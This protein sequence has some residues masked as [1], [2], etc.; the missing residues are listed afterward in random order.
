M[1]MKFLYIL[2]PFKNELLYIIE[3]QKKVKKMKINTLFYSALV[4]ITFTCFSC[5]SSN[6]QKESN[7]SETQ[8]IVTEDMSDIQNK[9]TEDSWSFEE[10]IYET[11]THE[12]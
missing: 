2:A 1:K 5:S 7:N 10:K 12:D 6:S 11:N 8:T 3:K 4:A 9:E